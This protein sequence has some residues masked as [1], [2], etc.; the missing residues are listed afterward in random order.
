VF[1][2][3]YGLSPYITQIRFVFG[4]L[5]WPPFV[6]SGGNVATLKVSLPEGRCKILVSV[7]LL[8]HFHS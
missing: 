2:A 6:R 7:T 5:R 4:R 8:E 1:T 3:R